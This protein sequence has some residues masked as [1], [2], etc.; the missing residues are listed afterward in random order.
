MKIVAI[1][2]TA[3]VVMFAADC[4]SACSAPRFRTVPGM[5]SN[6]YMTAQAGKPCSLHFFSAGPTTGTRI[7]QQPSHGTVRIGNIG[8]IIYKSK[9]GYVG[10]DS[11][12]YVRSGQTATGGSSERTVQVSV[13]V[14]P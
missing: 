2:L 4:A 9:L 1:V 7:V 8:H 5:T 6:G 13:T 3:G 14:T 11:F 10:P 12:S